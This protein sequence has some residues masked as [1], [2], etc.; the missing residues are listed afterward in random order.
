MA[1]SFTT[2]KLIE[3]PASGDYVNT[4]AAPVNNDWDII[5]TSFG[6]VTNLN[7]TGLSGTTTLT[8]SQYRPPII[9]VTGTLTANVTYLIPA[10]VGGYW[11]VYNNTTGSYLLTFVSGGGGT[12]YVVPQGYRA[13][14]ISDG[15]NISLMSNLPSTVAGS[16]G[17][18]QYNSSGSLAGSANF[19]FDGTNAAIGGNLTLSN[20]LT[21]VNTTLSGYLVATGYINA[22]GSITS[23]ANVTATGI[24][25]GASAT[26]TGAATVGSL[27]LKGSS[28]GSVTFKS[29]ASAGSTIYTFPATDGLAN[30]VL[31]TNGAGTLAWYTIPSAPATAAGSSTQ[32]Q[33][34]SGGL[35]AASANFTFDGSNLTVSGTLNSG[36]VSSGTISG[37]TISATSVSAG[38]VTTTG[39]GNVTVG[40][41]LVLKGATTGT[42]S[43][44]APS[45]AG[46]TTYTMPAS[47]GSANQ[48]L[49][50]NGAGTLNWYSIPTTAN[51]NNAVTFDNSNSGAAS[52]TTFNGSSAVTISANTFGALTS[53]SFTGSNQ[54]LA[55]SGYQ[56]L[57]GGLIIQWGYS[58]GS[59]NAISVSFPISFPN[60]VFSVTCNTANRTSSGSNGW[61]YVYGVSTSG[62]TML[63]ETNSTGGYTG[64]WMAIGY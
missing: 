43:L 31:Q 45:V 4:W 9:K 63:V 60:S 37:S 61:N 16:N 25:G 57:P 1:S 54:S 35:L 27:V 17:Q 28:S 41:S 42:V 58:T 51:T 26:I 59:S 47:D 64:Y 32:V 5:D 49:Q 39:T 24:L 38:S 50:T 44:K 18:V 2:N 8:I 34:N 33:Y 56:K 62:F 23:A 48:V 15:S 12:S 30:Q 36:S 53:S 40:G 46:S 14:I 13:L 3:K 55:S 20:S 52:G 7:A 21:A 29:P 11:S 22:S 6:G 10:G 19:T